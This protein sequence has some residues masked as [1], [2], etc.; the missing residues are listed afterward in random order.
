MHGRLRSRPLTLADNCIMLVDMSIWGPRKKKEVINERDDRYILCI[1]GGGMRGVVPA[2]LLKKLS[3]LLKEAGDERP[4]YAHFDLIAGTSTGGLLALALAAPA[5]RTGL[6][7][8]TL[9]P[10]PFYAL[11]DAQ[12]PWRRILFGQTPPLSVGTIP[13][14]VDPAQLLDLY[15]ESGREIFPK[16]PSRPLSILGPIFTDK[17]NE[18]PLSRLLKRVFD[19]IPLS[20]AVVPVMVVAYDTKYAAPVV[21]SSRDGHGFLMREAAR[22]TSAAP[23]YFSP[24][25]LT[26]RQ[27]GKRLSLIDGGVIANNPVLF[28]YLEAKKLYPDAKRFHILSFSTASTTFTFDA[29]KT[30]GGVIGWLDPAKGAPIQKIYS[31]S[32]MQTSDLLAQGIPDLD[33]I[34]VHGAIGQEKVK[35]DDTSDSA[36]QKLQQ[37][38]EVIYQENKE[39]LRGFAVQLSRRTNF[40]Q[41]RLPEE[42]AAEESIGSVEQTVTQ[43]PT[44]TL[45]VTNDVINIPNSEYNI[46]NNIN[47]TQDAIVTRHVRRKE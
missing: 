23:T 3:E 33:Y 9:P 32:Q 30:G 18:K 5:S 39:K 42:P 46:E 44:G 25:I 12:P 7:Q 37:G 21:L 34:R 45:C 19:D 8:E 35:L 15:L 14:G 43:E 22:A 20:D 17:Y 6:R 47:N 36:M 38:A 29:G 1:D 13:T 40:D 2:V 28:A 26:D 24:A 16:S 4:F 27:E 31:Q 41:L 11:P 10:A